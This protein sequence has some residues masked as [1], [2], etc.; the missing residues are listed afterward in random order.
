MRYPEHTHL[1]EHVQRNCHISDAR[2]AGDYTLCVYL[3]KMREY[4]RWEKSYSFNESLSTD[5]IGE[6]LTNREHLWDELEDEDYK[7]IEADNACYDPFDSSN[8]NEKLLKHGLVY[9]G[10]IG[11]KSKPHF[12]LAKL[13][14]E[15]RING[16]NILTTTEEYARDLTS[17]PAMSQGNTIFI[18]RESFK[19]MIWEKTEEWRWSKPENAM[20]RAMQCY[21]FDNNMEGSMEAMTDNELESAILHEIGEI[22]AGEKLPGWSD[23][24]HDLSRTQAEI[25]ARAVRD[26]LADAISTLP[27]LLE[28]RQDASIHF[29][30]ANLTNMRKLIFPSLI[31]AYNQWTGSHKFGGLQA[32]IENSQE[33]WQNIASQMLALHDKHEN[34]CSRHIELLVKNHYL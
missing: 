33:H 21:D 31:E 26:H 29:Y 25:M 24:M 6:W 28:Q 10:G 20:A 9:S 3:L 5:D 27:E 23:M 4:Y 11:H 16:Y 18:R 13:G 30:F 8:I 22:K 32:A 7:P 19:R 1:A 15:K 34:K 17:P 14:N 12:F 2:H